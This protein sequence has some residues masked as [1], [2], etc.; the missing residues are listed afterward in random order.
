M[1]WLMV[2]AR[3][4]PHGLAP[5]Q[6][7]PA[8]AQISFFCKDGGKDCF[9]FSALALSVMIKVYKY[10]LHRI[11]NLVSP[12]FFFI[13]TDLASLRRAI[14][15]NERISVTCF[16]MADYSSGPGVHAH[17]PQPLSEQRRLE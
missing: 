6:R 14:C 4:S 13:F 1:M 5:T 9:S 2:S 17:K 11:L 16:G 10:L 7:R 15:K 12:A 8:L 3:G